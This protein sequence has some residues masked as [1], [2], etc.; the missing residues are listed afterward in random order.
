[1]E[2]KQFD[3]EEFWGYCGGLGDQKISYFTVQ[4]IW[5]YFNLSLYAADHLSWIESLGLQPGLAQ[6]RTLLEGGF[7]SGK[8]LL[9]KAQCSTCQS[10]SA[11]TV[12]L[13]M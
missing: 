13:A 11:T 7:G 2:A 12:Q 9:G 3:E 6:Y 10:L 1:M 4:P 8:A 5:T